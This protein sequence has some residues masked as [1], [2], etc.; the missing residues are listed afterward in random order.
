MTEQD[1]ERFVGSSCYAGSP[2]RKNASTSPCSVT[3][4]DSTGS[5]GG[6]KKSLIRTRSPAIPPLSSVYLTFLLLINFP[7]FSPI[8]SADNPNRSRTTMR[9]SHGQ[10]SASAMSDTE[11]PGSSVP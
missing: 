9:K 6:G 10:H 5:Q 7:A 1:R 11:E 2:R 3:V 4:T 8:S